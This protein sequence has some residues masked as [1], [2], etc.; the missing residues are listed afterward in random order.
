MTAKQTVLTYLETRSP[1]HYTVLH[2]ARQT[3]LPRSSV[4]KALMSLRNEK[5]VE[6]D[7]GW[8]EGYLWYA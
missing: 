6:R 3:K 1:S 5:K 2:I 7:L 4:Q 8:G